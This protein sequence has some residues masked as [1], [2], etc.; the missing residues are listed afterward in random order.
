MLHDGSAGADLGLSPHA[1]MK[2]SFIAVPG[3]SSQA[4]SRKPIHI[5]GRVAQHFVESAWADHGLSSAKFHSAKATGSAPAFISAT[6]QPGESSQ[7]RD[8]SGKAADE[9]RHDEA[10]MEAVCQGCRR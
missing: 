7:A 4:N 1:A 10:A 2:P 5:P 8:A 6:K 3:E 9:L